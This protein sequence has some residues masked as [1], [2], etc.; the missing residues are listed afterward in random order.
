MDF[1]YSFVL[2][3][4]C[5]DPYWNCFVGDNVGYHHRNSFESSHSGTYLNLGSCTVAA[6]CFCAP[7]FRHPNKYTS[8]CS[9]HNRHLFQEKTHISQFEFYVDKTM[10]V[11]DL[12]ADVKQ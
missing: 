2:Q 1:N 9:D 10:V 5:F 12:Q 4:H 8:W 3:L 11:V 7:K 6:I